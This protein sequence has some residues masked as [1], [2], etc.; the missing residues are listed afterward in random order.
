MSGDILA[1]SA[2]ERERSGVV[3]AIVEG[4]LLQWEGAEQL[5]I[6]LRQMKRL[7][8][9]WREAGD[10]GLVSRQRGRLSPLRLASATQEQIVSLLRG[11][12]RVLRWYYG[13]SPFYY[14][15]IFAQ[16]L[17]AVCFHPSATGTKGLTVI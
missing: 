11:V 8:R 7:L 12:L 1:M 15:V 3:R 4:R 2:V 10:A 17:H 6:C 5:G 9:N 13:A 14:P 16:S